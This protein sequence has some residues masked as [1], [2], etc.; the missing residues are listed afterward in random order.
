[1]N[2]DHIHNATDAQLA[3]M[4]ED[5]IPVPREEWAH[6]INE[7]SK[8]LRNIQRILDAKTPFNHEQFE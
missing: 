6:I 2:Y 5:P 8:R 7:A 4:L 1:M 3:D